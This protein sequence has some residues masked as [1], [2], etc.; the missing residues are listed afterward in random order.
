MY[1]LFVY[2][3]A[4]TILV[5]SLNLLF[6]H[7]LIIRQA[8]GFVREDLYSPSIIIFDTSFCRTYLCH[9]FLSI[10]QPPRSFNHS[11]LVICP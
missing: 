7:I 1:P 6:H 3:W 9:S 8:T 10:L 2:H 11:I 4:Y 5:V